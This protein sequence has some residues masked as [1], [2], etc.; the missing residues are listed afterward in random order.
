[1]DTPKTVM[2]GAQA[3][4]GESGEISGIVYKIAITRKYILA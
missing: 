3:V 1:M 4:I 2:S